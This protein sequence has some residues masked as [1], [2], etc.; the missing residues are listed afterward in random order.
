MRALKIIALISVILLCISGTVAIAAGVYFNTS[1]LR[2]EIYLSCTID[3]TAEI[4]GGYNWNLVI[5]KQLSSVRWEGFGDKDRPRTT[6][7]FSASAIRMAWENN[8][9]GHV[10]M[11]VNRLDGTFRMEITSDKKIPTIR[12]HCYERQPQF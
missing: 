9:G 10:L 11:N 8:E 12:G 4:E 1:W 3:D 6:E 5:D 2:S 7:Y